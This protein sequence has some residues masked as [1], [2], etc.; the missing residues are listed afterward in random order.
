MPDPCIVHFTRYPVLS[1]EFSRA[2]PDSTLRRPPFA[3]AR[4]STFF[5]VSRSNLNSLNL[6]NEGVL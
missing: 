1:P 3:A 5:G 2:A 6:L 4:T